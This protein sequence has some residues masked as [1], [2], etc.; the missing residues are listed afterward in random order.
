M[1]NISWFIPFLFSTFLSPVH[2]STEKESCIDLTFS[3]V[4]IVSLTSKKVTIEYTIK[5]V[6]DENVYLIGGKKNRLGNVAI[7][8][9]LSGDNFLNQGDIL[10]DAFYLS[11]IPNKGLLT[12][13]QSY[14]GTSTVK[15][16]KKTS[17]TSILILKVD[18]LNLVLE[19][20]ESNNNYSLFLG[21]E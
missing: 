19:C 18:A 20:S 1:F 9:Y 21:E 3:E 13:G 6:G 15:L 17:F 11:N 14:V 4:K 7:Q 8:A 10:C 2:P 12:P 5:N 16:R